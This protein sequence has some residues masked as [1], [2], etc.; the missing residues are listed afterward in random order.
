[1]QFKSEIV[2]EFADRLYKEAEHI[3]SSYVIGY[4]ALPLAIG[5]GLAYFK[6]D[7]AVAIIS[8]PVVIGGAALGYYQGKE[9]AFQLKL[10]AQTALCH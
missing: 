2:E 1:M 4:A 3:I 8:I 5:A 7:P 9:K 6:G 10:Q